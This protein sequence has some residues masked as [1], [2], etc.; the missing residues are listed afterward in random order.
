MTEKNN[1]HG[2][3]MYSSGNGSVGRI[4]KSLVATV[5]IHGTEWRQAAGWD[6]RFTK[7]IFV[8][9]HHPAPWH[10]SHYER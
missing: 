10:L 9:Y 4:A 2:L 1:I 8:F 7:L 6:R 3:L 5:A